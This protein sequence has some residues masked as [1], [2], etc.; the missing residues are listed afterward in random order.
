MCG[1]AGCLQ[2]PGRGSLA[3]SYTAASRTFD[4]FFDWLNRFYDRVLRA[5][6]GHRGRVFGVAALLVLIAGAAFFFMRRE[7]S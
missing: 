6:L 3:S 2:T 5:A 7:L 4:A 1:I